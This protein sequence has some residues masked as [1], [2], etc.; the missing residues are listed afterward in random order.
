MTDDMKT[1]PVSAL[2][3]DKYGIT[4]GITCGVTNRTDLD[5]LVE[6][7]LQYLDAEEQSHAEARVPVQ[8]G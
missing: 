2:G 1:V 3:L 7:S 8:A 5:K 4:G 6:F